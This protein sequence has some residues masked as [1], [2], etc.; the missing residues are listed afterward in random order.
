MR[1]PTGTWLRAGLAAVLGLALLAGCTDDPK[2]GTLKTPT[3]TPTSTTASPTAT[4]PE[5]QIEA[6]MR[7][8]F[9]VTN[10]AI[11]SG[12]VSKLVGFSTAGC[13]C[14]KAA[15]EI[16]R[17]FSDGGHFEGLRY[18]V[19]RI[20]VHDI[21]QGTGLAEVVATLPPYKV[22]DGDGDVTEDSA[23]GKLHTDFSLVRS[24]DRWIIGN[25][26]NLE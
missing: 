7:S 9:D 24:G 25:A 6:T 8:Y 13:P 22:F 2:P 11:Q 14:R 10:A 18:E 23:G 26:L 20:R 17:T 16:R 5:A 1:T 15:R 12:D 19:Q 3:A 21:E 4:T